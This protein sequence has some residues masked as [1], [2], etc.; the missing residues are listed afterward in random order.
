LGG[1]S[2]QVLPSNLGNVSAIGGLL[3]TM[4]GGAGAFSIRDNGA[5]TGGLA[6]VIGQAARM[7]VPNSFGSAM[8]GI[9]SKN[10]IN[11]VA[12]QVLPIVIS[13][14]DLGS[15]SSMSTMCSPGA[16]KMMNPS[17]IS[18]VASS[19]A[20]SAGQSYREQISNYTTVTETFGRIDPGWATTSRITSSGTDNAINITNLQGASPDFMTMME[21]GIRSDANAT[22]ET[23]A[24]LVAR[25]FPPTDVQSQL[26]EQYPSMIISE[27]KQPVFTDP[28]TVAIINDAN[29]RTRAKVQ[30]DID[31][32]NDAWTAALERE[33]N[34]LMQE[35]VRLKNAGQADAAYA[36]RIEAQNMQ[37]LINAKYTQIIDKL[38]DEFATAAR[39]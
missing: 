26:K 33:Y 4:S 13:K 15:L 9:S 27:P 19:Y 5:L 6:G 21:T 18:N 1:V 3:N 14:C 11:Q 22:P 24:L 38:S 31:D 25:E 16:L 17:I 20:V 34:P 32:A 23:Q 12:G 37:T 2:R 10:I 29:R 7:G 39:Y 36:K 8:T 28:R 30:A 35:A